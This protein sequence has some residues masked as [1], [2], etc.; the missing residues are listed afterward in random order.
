MAVSISAR[1]ISE[2]SI[3]PD[4]FS[5]L[6]RAMV[7]LRKTSSARCMPAS[8][9][10]SARPINFSSSSVF[11]SRSGQN[12]WLVER[13]RILFAASSAAYAQKMGEH[14]FIRRRLFRFALH[15]ALELVERDELIRLRLFAPAAHFHVAQDKRALAVLLE[16]NEWVRREKPRC[17]KHVRVGFAR[18]YNQARRS[19]SNFGFWIS[20]FHFRFVGPPVDVAGSS[21]A[22]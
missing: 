4:H 13:T 5:L 3:L 12:K 6:S 21:L 15:F 19:I 9:M 18:G 22:E 14:F 17:V 2:V 20:G 7:D 1:R 11:A 16:K 8:V 10:R